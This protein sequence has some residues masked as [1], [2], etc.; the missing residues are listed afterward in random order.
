MELGIGSSRGIIDVMALI[1]HSSWY[2]REYTLTKCPNVFSHIILS[3]IMVMWH[4]ATRT[5]QQLLN[6]SSVVG[7]NI[8]LPAL[9]I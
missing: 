3:F 8:P 6:H 5:Y 7:P 9:T 4:F 1:C 2:P